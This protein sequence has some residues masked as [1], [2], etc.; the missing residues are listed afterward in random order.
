M[1]TTTTT[2]SSK[3]NNV[4]NLSENEIEYKHTRKS[5]GSRPTHSETKEERYHGTVAVVLSG[6]TGKMIGGRVH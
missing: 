6:S 4:V 2:S 5:D 1:T 3:E